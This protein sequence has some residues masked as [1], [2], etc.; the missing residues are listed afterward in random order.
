[1]VP[2]AIL[3]EVDEARRVVDRIKELLPD[4][5]T[6]HDD[7]S[8]SH[9]E[10][11]NRITDFHNA[12]G[13]HDLDVSVH[14]NAYENTS[15]PMGTECLYVTQESSVQGCLG[16][17]CESLW[18]AQPRSQEEHRSPFSQSVCMHRPF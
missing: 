8:T 11:L 7:I 14:F 5:V 2:L 4:I 17:N 13:K 15:K 12:Q 1:M 6:Y 18:I 3:D 10:N 9:N 16:G